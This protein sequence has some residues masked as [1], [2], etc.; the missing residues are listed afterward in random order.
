MRRWIEIVREAG[1]VESVPKAE[2]RGDSNFLAAF[3]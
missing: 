2:I 3:A 1:S